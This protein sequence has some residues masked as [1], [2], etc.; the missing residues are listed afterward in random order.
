MI[1]DALASCVAR[2]SA[3]MILAMKNK[4]AF[5]FHEKDLNYL[6][7]VCKEKSYILCKYIFILPMKK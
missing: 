6:R 3:N 1:A 2:T 4:Q 7:Y 5:V